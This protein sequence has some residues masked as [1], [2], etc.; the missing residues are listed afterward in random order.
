MLKTTINSINSHEVYDTVVQMSRGKVKCAVLR[1]VCAW[2]DSAAQSHWWGP[3]AGSGGRAGI[4]STL[5]ACWGKKTVFEP[6]GFGLETLQ[7]PPAG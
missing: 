6:T 5:T 2:A 3:E 1:L 7:P 4:L